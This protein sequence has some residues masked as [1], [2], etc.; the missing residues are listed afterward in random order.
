V[1]PF[2]GLAASREK[3]RKDKEGKSGWFH[4]LDLGPFYSCNRLQLIFCPLTLTTFRPQVNRRSIFV[5]HSR[6]N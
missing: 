2:L 5:L 6:C 4:E 3:H 1:R